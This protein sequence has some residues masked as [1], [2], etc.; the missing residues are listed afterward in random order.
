MRIETNVEARRSPAS[1]AWC[2]FAARNT[3]HTLYVLERVMLL[4][5]CKPLPALLCAR[6]ISLLVVPGI[7]VNDPPHPFTADTVVQSQ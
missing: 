2:T 3:K 1:T 5:L 7:V 4:P 6:P